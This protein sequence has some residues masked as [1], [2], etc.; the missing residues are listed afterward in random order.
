MTLEEIEWD[1]IYR[2]FELLRGR[3]KW[4]NDLKGAQINFEFAGGLNY[5]GIGFAGELNVIQTTSC[6]NK[7]MVLLSQWQRGLS[8]AFKDVV[9]QIA[10]AYCERDERSNC[11]NAVV[12]K[13]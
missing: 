2:E 4:E 3:N 6:Q 13:R 11:Y 10:V 9:T 1:S 12:A 8:Q 5:R 7:R